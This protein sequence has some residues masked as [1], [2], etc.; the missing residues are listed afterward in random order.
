[1][2]RAPFV[3]VT[4]C[5]LATAFLG[6]LQWATR[7]P[8]A[9][10]QQKAKLRAFRTILERENLKNNM[11]NN[12]KTSL[13]PVSEPFLR[14]AIGRGE[15]VEGSEFVKAVYILPELGKQEDSQGAALTVLALRGRGYS[16][17]LR[18]YAAYR[19]DGSLYHAVLLPSDETPGLGKRAEDPEY[20]RMFWDQSGAE[21]EPKSLLL[22][23]RTQMGA[24]FGLDAISGS[25]I[26]FVGIAR[27]LKAGSAY[28][29]KNQ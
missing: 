1:M 22:R 23:S 14:E 19:G 11:Q 24:K 29:Q 3:L 25:T 10:A 8:I 21:L 15:E 16:G 20:M 28:L 26:S 9:A 27:A 5:L 2:Y 18:L 12:I 13:Q 4:I 6:L 17:T 7:E